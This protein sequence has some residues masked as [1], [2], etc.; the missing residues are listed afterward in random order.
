MAMNLFEEIKNS[1]VHILDTNL[2]TLFS[3]ETP[4]VFEIDYTSDIPASW[5]CL[6]C[7]QGNLLS[8]WQGIR[9]L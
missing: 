8:K 1:G 5:D 9:S 4:A 2:D 3:D 7:S 6:L